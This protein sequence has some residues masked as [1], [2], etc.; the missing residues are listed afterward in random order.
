MKQPICKRY[1]SLAT[2]MAFGYAM[3]HGVNAAH[4][5]DAIAMAE[6]MAPAPDGQ[7]DLIFQNGFDSACQGGGCVFQI[8]GLTGGSFNTVG[9]TD[10]S[11]FLWLNRFSP[12]S[13]DYPFTLTEITTIFGASG[14]AV[15]EHFDIYVYQDDDHD[16]TNGA[17]LV[18]SLEGAQVEAPL[19]TLQTVVFPFGG[20]LLI[21]PGD[22]LIALVNRDAIGYYPASADEGT[23]FANRSWVGGFDSGVPSMPDLSQLGLA[24][25]P[26]ALPGFT[27]NWVVRGRG[28]Q[29]GGRPVSLRGEE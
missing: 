18:G 16:P 8:D 4:A 7:G 20:I 26:S 19:N 14:A 12:E 23:A 6:T 3:L 27:H 24:L 28:V 22:V 21:G 10:H 9:A 25:T 5:A 17:T 1:S 11:T 13:T 2:A 29:W 15:G